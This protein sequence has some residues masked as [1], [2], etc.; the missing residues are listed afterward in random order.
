MK[1]DKRTATATLLVVKDDIRTAAG[2]CGGAL[3]AR[4]R[5]PAL[6]GQG[7]GVLLLCPLGL[8]RHVSPPPSPRT[9]RSLEGGEGSLSPFTHNPNYT[10]LPKVHRA[11]LFLRRRRSPIWCPSTLSSRASRSCQSPGPHVKAMGAMSLLPI[12][13]SLFTCEDYNTYRAHP[14]S[15]FPL[16]RAHPVPGPHTAPHLVE[17]SG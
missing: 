13:D 7:P 14:W 15:P 16:R 8:L 5:V 4:V 6:R 2:R 17:G 9:R 10:V 1:D 12:C 3:E 11:R